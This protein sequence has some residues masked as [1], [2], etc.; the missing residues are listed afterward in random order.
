MATENTGANENKKAGEA[1]R[2]PRPADLTPV[3]EQVPILPEAEESP[4]RPDRPAPAEIRLQEGPELKRS[5]CL[6]RSSARA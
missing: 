4:D 5:L 3:E 2:K 6:T 1:A